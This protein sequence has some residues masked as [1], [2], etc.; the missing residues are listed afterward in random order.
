MQLCDREQGS[1]SAILSCGLRKFY[2]LSRLN[3]DPAKI[4][5]QVVKSMDDY[6]VH[7]IAQL[8]RHLPILATISSVAPPESTVAATRAV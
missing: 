5:E 4:D 8:E 2:V 6:S 7:I 3:Y 1:V